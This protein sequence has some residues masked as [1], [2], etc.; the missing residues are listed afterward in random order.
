MTWSVILLAA[1]RKMLDNLRMNIGILKSTG[2]TS[3]QLLLIT[4]AIA[5]WT[6][7]AAASCARETGAALNDELH[8]ISPSIEVRM[9][10][11]SPGLD[12]LNIDS[13]GL[14]KRGANAIRASSRP[15]TNFAGTVLNTAGGK[16][17]DYCRP[18]Q[19]PNTSPS[20]SLEVSERHLLLISQWSEAGAPEAL[21]L[22]F[23]TSRC[24]TT[25]LGILNGDG[26]L[27]LPGQGSLRITATGMKDAALGYA[28]KRGGD[29]TVTFPPATKAMPR[30]EYRLEVAA[31]YPNLPGIAADHR[32]D[33]FRRNWL[34]VLQLNPS[35][36]QLANNSGSTSCAFCYY[37]YATSPRKLRRWRTGLPHWMW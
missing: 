5:V 16:R 7:G 17:V 21:T 4:V 13:L 32:F 33:S 18:G 19:P 37:E 28:A 3:R 26:T 1:A 35:L 31:I 34:N 10:P 14:G 12:A 30:I 8:F 9:S 22:T 2:S 25:V 23:D 24:H 6:A 29:V 20:W 11:R 15:N 36:R 27:H